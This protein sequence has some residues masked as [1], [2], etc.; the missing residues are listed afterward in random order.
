MEHGKVVR[1]AAAALGT[2]LLAAACGPAAPDEWTDSRDTTL[3]F[4]DV[5]EEAGVAVSHRAPVDAQGESA[6]MMGGAAVGDFDND[7]RQDIFLIG[8]GSR[9]DALFVNAGDG[10]FVDMADRAGLTDLYLGSAATAG[11]FDGDGWLDIFVSSHGTE[12]EGPVPG[13]HRLYRNNGDL[14]F[15]DVAEAAG[16]NMTSRDEV[17]GFGAAFGDVDLDGDLDLFVAGW[18][19]DSRGNRLFR[20][21]GDGTFVDVTDAAGIDGDRARGLSPCI[22]D[23]DGD[24]FPEIL[25][26]ADFGTT[27]YFAN[28]GDGTFEDRTSEAGVGLEWSGMGTTVGDFNQD[29]LIDWYTS[30]IYDEDNFGRGDGN[31]MYLNQGDHEFVE[32]AANARVDDGGWGWGV[33]AVDLDLDGLLDLVETNGWRMPAYENEMAKVWVQQA[34]STFTDVAADSGLDHDQFGLG[35]MRLDL[36]GDGDQDIAIT[37]NNGAFRLYET[38][39]EGPQPSWLRIMLDTSANP[40][41]APNGVGAVVRVDAGGSSQFSPVVGCSNYASSSELT[42]HFGLGAADSVDLVTVEWPDGTATELGEVDVNQTITIDAR[43]P[44]PS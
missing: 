25:L 33:V 40:D 14:T 19:R 36:E 44:L 32:V 34:D 3:R 31:K 26:V 29:G 8:G 43:G 28:R 39:L 23:T 11:D 21:E 22:V 10:V 20:N 5:T 42:A 30:A 13:R 9:P 37:S 35:L 2:F 41:L 6:Q 7:G 27:R 15:T 4:V 12:A 38:H 18:K 24:R 17:D 1:L 16:V